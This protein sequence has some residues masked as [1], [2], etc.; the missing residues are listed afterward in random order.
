MAAGSDSSAA[1][2]AVAGY[3]LILDQYASPVQI[4][5]RIAIYRDQLTSRPFQ[6]MNVTVARHLHV[7]E[8]RSET[9]AAQRRHAAGTQRILGAARDPSRPADGSHVLAY[10]HPGAAGAHY[11][12]G[13]PD[14]IADDLG[15][16]RQAG[17]SYVL[18][19]PETDIIQLR[20]F[21]DDVIPRLSQPT[22]DGSAGRV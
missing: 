22:S 19:I 12:Y 6:A 17:V 7:A 18:L 16:L 21:C 14:Q 20:Q 9:A 15:V 4:T 10:Q 11:L 3:N 8:S 2:A 5:D 13:T 1:R